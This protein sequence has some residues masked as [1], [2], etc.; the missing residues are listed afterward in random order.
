MQL[1]LEEGYAA[2]TARRVAARAGLKPQLVHYYFPTM[3]DLL[4]A[5]IRHG[6]D[7]SLQQLAADIGSEQ[8]LNAVWKLN[9]D[10]ETA[11][12]SMQFLALAM[13]RNAVRAE[14][15]RYAEQLRAIQTEAFTRYLAAQGIASDVPPIAAVLSLT[16][17]SQLIQLENALGISLGHGETRAVVDSYLAS[18]A[19][20][21]GK[22]AEKASGQSRRRGVRSRIKAR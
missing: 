12:L 21:G 22:P 8:P 10:V 9:N 20:N 11:M 15:K 13:H 5:V 3:D 6:G 14:V 2:V 18:S 7:I 16:A 4:V 17:V 19:S 1:M